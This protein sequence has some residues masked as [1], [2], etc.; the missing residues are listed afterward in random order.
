[1]GYLDVSSVVGT[2][3]HLKPKILY[4]V[5]EDWY[6][7]SHRLS[8]ACAVRDAG[9]EVIV[10]TRVHTHGEDIRREGF[11]LV[12]IA[13][14]RSPRTPW[15][16]LWTLF[17]VGR[18]YRTER[19][20]IVH[21]VAMKPVVYG[22]IVAA[23]T[24]GSTVVNALTGLGYVFSSNH[25]KARVLRA[26]IMYTLRWLLRG[27]NTWLI[28][29]NLDD[30]RLLVDSGVV[31][32]AHITVIPGSGVDTS[33]FKPVL[34]AGGIPTV[35]LASRMLWD[36]GVGEFVAAAKRLQEEG[37][38]ARFVL[39]GDTDP[40]NPSAI[41]TTMLTQWQRSGAIEWWG[42]RTDMAEVF[43]QSHI[44]CLPSYREGL[45][46][47]LIEAAAAGRPIVTTDTPGCRSVVKDGD[48]GLL[49]PVRDVIALSAA[50]KRLINNASLRRQMGIA[51]RLLAETEFTVERITGETIALYRHILENTKSHSQ[52]QC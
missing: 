27:P 9:F 49:V 22:S 46:K 8:L 37:I 15:Q 35:L 42:W 40:E 17:A 47:V 3:D 16:D 32:A 38:A 30:W 21:H 41:P 7:C 51:G 6:F 14:S 1:V 43:K 33:E 44:V 10:V 52:D 18:I 25:C 39:V 31:D 34:E 50:L 48:N 20:D 2:L 19:P 5:T 45:P 24:G 12:P 36:K 13:F 23:M 28:L 11:K 4:L 29:Q 26:L